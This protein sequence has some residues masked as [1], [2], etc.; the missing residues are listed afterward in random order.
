MKPQYDP[1]YFETVIP[2]KCECCLKCWLIVA[3]KFTGKCVHG[4]P[5]KGYVEVEDAPPWRAP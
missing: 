4:G 1:V 5:Y 2:W 3:G